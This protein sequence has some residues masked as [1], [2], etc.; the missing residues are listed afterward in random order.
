M[1]PV[2]LTIFSDSKEPMQSS[3]CK[4]FYIGHVRHRE[5]SE[6]F[7]ILWGERTEGIPK[8]VSLC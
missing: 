8:D 3:K 4:R 7:T 6:T 2:K 1:E 5:C